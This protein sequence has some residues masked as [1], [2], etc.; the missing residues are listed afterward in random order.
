MNI[1]NFDYYRRL[2]TNLAYKQG[3]VQIINRLR[4]AELAGMSGSAEESLAIRDLIR[5]SG[6]NMGVTFP[7]MFPEYLPGQT[8][9]EP[10]TLQR[11]PFAYAMTTLLP[12]SS[13]TIRAGR[14]AAKSTTLAAKALA[15]AHFLGFRQLYCAPRS[16]Q[17]KTYARKVRELERACRVK[18]RGA[19]LKQNDYYKEYA[20][21]GVFELINA[22]TSADNARGKTTDILDIDEA[23]N[24]DESLYPELVMV[25]KASRW[26]IINYSGTSLDV[27]TFLEACYQRGSKGTWHIPLP[28][29][30]KVGDRLYLDCGDQATVLGAIR[31]QGL[32]CPHTGRLLD[33]TTGFFVHEY[34]Q[35]FLDRQVSLHVPQILIP[36]YAM[37]PGWRDIYGPFK[38]W[39]TSKFLQEIMGIPTEAG[40]REL[41][42]TELVRICTLGNPDSGLDRVRR[43]EYRYVVSG[44]DWGGSDYNKADRTKVSYTVHAILGVTRDGQFDILHMRQYAGMN[45]REVATDILADHK[46]YQATALASDFG[47]GSAYNMLLREPGGIPIDRHLVMGYVGPKSA[48]LSEP[49]GDHMANQWSLNR[50]ESITQ[51]FLAIKQANPRIRCYNWEDAYPRLSELLNMRRVQTESETTGLTGMR[52]LRAGDKP[53][54]TLHAINFAFTLGR[55]LLGEQLLED[56]GLRYK[57]MHQLNTPVA[58]I[59]QIPTPYS[60]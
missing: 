13:T 23:Q 2:T 21:G 59:Q 29:R 6:W 10:L 44:C 16:D 8:G 5:Y 28:C 54:D 42:E 37:G 40:V 27:D 30:N 17:T 4:K 60:G 52:Y 41:S 22:Y 24:F 53:D 9:N 58:Q 25:M 47:A 19:R 51:L 45:Y 46:R 31:E 56:P 43:G 11:R 12:Y 57:L 26:P 20:N 50:Q 33:P 38:E 48:I 49:S 32:S 15:V 36:E 35:R 3:A 1:Q 39:P 55:L 34:Q 14:Q 18:I 7:V